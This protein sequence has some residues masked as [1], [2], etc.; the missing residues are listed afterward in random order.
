MFVVPI[1][2]SDS[3]NTIL[4]FY[5]WGRSGAYILLVH[6][7]KNPQPLSSVL[8]WN[9]VPANRSA[10]Y[11]ITLYTDL[12]CYMRPKLPFTPPPSHAKWFH[13]TQTQIILLAFP[14]TYLQ[15][16]SC[17]HHLQDSPL[18]H[19]RSFILQYILLI[20]FN[21]KYFQLMSVLWGS[22]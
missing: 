6:S 2:H 5:T 20:N 7:Q 22:L 9:N 21:M 10:S 19:L 8:K 3:F 12:I 15:P 1:Y 16:K 13:H 14:W 18:L 4:I 11:F 17:T